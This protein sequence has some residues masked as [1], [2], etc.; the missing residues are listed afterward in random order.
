MLDLFADRFSI[1]SCKPAGPGTNSNSWKNGR[2]LGTFD[3]SLM[4]VWT[5]KTVLGSK[6]RCEV[7]WEYE[8]EWFPRTVIFEYVREPVKT[9]LPSFW[10]LPQSMIQGS[11]GASTFNKTSRDAKTVS[12]RTSPENYCSAGNWDKETQEG[13]RVLAMASICELCASKFSLKSHP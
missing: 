6:P 3:T 8:R 12:P 9:E 1:R 10:Y 13:K 4:F 11:L 2:F 7:P 5:N